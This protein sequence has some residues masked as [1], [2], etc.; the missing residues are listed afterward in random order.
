MVVLPT[1]EIIEPK[2]ILFL[3]LISFL[4]SLNEVPKSCLS[5]FEDARLNSDGKNKNEKLMKMLLF[6]QK[7]YNFKK[8]S[9]TS[10]T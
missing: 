8:I 9:K 4:K 2:F 10:N 1:T 3:F 6:L 7:K 5:K